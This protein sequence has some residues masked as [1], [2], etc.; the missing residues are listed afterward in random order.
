MK[1]NELTGIK[2][3]K[4]DKEHIKDY[5]D[6]LGF[7]YLDSGCY[8]STYK[9]KN[10]VLKV[11]TDDPAYEAYINFIKSIPTEYKKFTPK[12]TSVR[13]FPQNKDIKFIKLEFL[14][15]LNNE[16]SEIVFYTNYFLND[17]Y[18][19]TNKFEDI[20]TLEKIKN[21]YKNNTNTFEQYSDY[22]DFYLLEFLYFL[23]SKTSSNIIWD[24]NDSN[25]MMRGNQLVVTDPWA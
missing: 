17:L 6:L 9:G 16:N 13:E 10:A 24:I 15:E 22:I 3:I 7:E 20:D 2:N 4:F 23:K 5:L 25:I 12:V 14:E 8:A 11:F 18:K 1:L 21:Y 19:E